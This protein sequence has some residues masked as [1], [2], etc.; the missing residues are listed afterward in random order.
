MNADGELLQPDASAGDLRFVDVNNDGVIDVDDRTKIGDPNP[1]FTYGVTLNVSYGPFD[2]LIFGQ[3]VAG[4][5]IYNATRRFDLPSSNYPGDALGRW[6]GEGT[7]ND[8]PRIIDGDPNRN[9]SRSSD[10]FVEDGSFFRI[11]TLQIGFTVPQD[12]LDRIGMKSARFYVSGNNI[13]TFTNYKGF[14]PEII[15]GVDRGIYPQPRFYL[16]GVNIG[17]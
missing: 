13:L 4:N 6:T 3:G 5:E 11:K 9:F 10:F 8:F 2:V 14:D 15:G 16:V 1:D 12:V 7:S 17:I